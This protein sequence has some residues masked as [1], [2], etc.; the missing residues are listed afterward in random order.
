MVE[1]LGWCLVMKP[2]LHDLKTYATVTG[3]CEDDRRS[4]A[5]RILPFADG[6]SRAIVKSFDALA[7]V[8]ESS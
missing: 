7:S 5:T 4:T 6:M 3:E 1:S 8:L 2:S